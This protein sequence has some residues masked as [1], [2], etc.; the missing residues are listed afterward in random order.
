MILCLLKILTRDSKDFK[1]SKN[2]KDFENSNE[3]SLHIKSNNI[4]INIGNETDEIIK[5]LL[6]S[7]LQRYQEGLKESIRR[8]NLLVILQASRNKSKSWWIIYRFS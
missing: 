2:S 1:D 7:L 4:G 8:S 3:T 5:E 6:K